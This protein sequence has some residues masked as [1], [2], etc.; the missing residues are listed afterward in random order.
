MNKKYKKLIFRA[1]AIAL[2]LAGLGGVTSA[3]AALLVDRGLPTGN[4]NIA[5]GSNRSNVAWADPVSST[6]SIGDNFTLSGASVINDIRAWVV[7]SP[8]TGFANNAFQLWLGADTGATTS[9]TQ[10]SLSTSVTSTT[11]S[12]SSTYQGSSG[13]YFDIYQV[14]FGGLNLS[15][16]GGTYAFSISGPTDLGFATPFLSASNGPL[17]GST[18]MGDDGIIYGFTAT[19]A[20][21][22]GNG[23]P[24]N[25]IGGWDKN[26][27]INVQ[28]FGATVPEPT[29]LALLGIALAGLGA[30]R[31]RKPG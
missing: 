27:D 30:M 26:S 13:N 24:W 8:Q 20:M 11:Y 25:T 9:V 18:Q 31:R 17:S 22:S 21:D 29:T 28:V 1:G 23:Y 4:L 10:L 12:D 6:V 7:S 3:N 2:V 5:A 16:S 14:D 19:G 15:E